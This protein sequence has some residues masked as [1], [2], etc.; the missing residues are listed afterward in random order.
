MSKSTRDALRVSYMNRIRDFLVNA[1]EE[2]L[3]TG[4]NEF[5]LP[6][7]DSEGNDE[8]IVLTVKVPTGSRD[9]EPYDGYSMAEDFTMKQAEKARRKRASAPRP[10]KPPQRSR[11]RWSAMRKHAQRSRTARRR[12]RHDRKPRQRPQ[13][14]MQAPSKQGNT[15]GR[16][17]TVSLFLFARPC[18]ILGHFTTLPYYHDTTL[19]H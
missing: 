9:G 7:V 19:T 5:A 4:T 14:P 18:S 1:G 12:I 10:R 11:R 13:P 6:C 2:V 8:F 15:T 3:Q 16:R 17:E